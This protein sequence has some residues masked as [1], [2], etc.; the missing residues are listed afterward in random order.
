MKNASLEK[1][2]S[3]P[4]SSSLWESFLR[5]SRNRTLAVLIYTAVL[6]V[7]AVIF[8]NVWLLLIGEG[9]LWGAVFLWNSFKN[10]K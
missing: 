9:A 5:D 2:N 3:H 6:A 4:S 10:K 8:R 7:L 1:E